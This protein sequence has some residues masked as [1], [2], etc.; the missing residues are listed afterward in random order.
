MKKLLATSL[1]ILILLFSCGGGGDGGHSVLPPPG[2]NVIVI[3]DIPPPPVPDDNT[4]VVVVPPVPTPVP[5]PVPPPVT[6]VLGNATWEMP[7]T[8]TDGTPILSDVV[9]SVLLFMK[10][11]ATPFDNNVDLPIAEALPGATSVNF[12]PVEGTAGTTSYFSA[13]AKT[14]TGEISDFSPSVTHVWE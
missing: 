13:K 14:N 6:P 3:P 5:P 12:G 7:T 4:I 1:F 10:A 2:D 9:L 11:T 8:Y